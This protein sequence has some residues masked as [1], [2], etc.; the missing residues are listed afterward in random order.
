MARKPAS[1]TGKKVKPQRRV[2]SMM[3]QI[4]IIQ[5]FA[6][7]R[8]HQQIRDDFKTQFGR[9]IPE[10]R[11]KDLA[12]IKMCNGD[13]KLARK[14][15][16]LTMMPFFAQAREAFNKQT[17][18]IA[19][20]NAVYRIKLLDDLLGQALE[21]KNW[22]TAANLLKQAEQATNNLSRPRASQTPTD[23]D[24]SK[25]VGNVLVPDEAKAD[26]VVERLMLEFRKQ[27]PDSAA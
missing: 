23:D 4:W 1:P 11:L 3:E 27:L 7:Y 12:R 17:A 2:L 22:H 16:V 15:Q 5:Q 14:Y 10:T 13:E 19:I 6:V 20:A 18:E 21:K 9:D 24:F 25:G 8:R 26:D